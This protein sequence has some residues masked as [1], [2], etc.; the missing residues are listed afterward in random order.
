GEDAVLVS[1]THLKSSPTRGEGPRRRR[2][3]GGGAQAPYPAL[4]KFHHGAPAPP[5]SC[6][7]SPSPFRGGF[8]ERSSPLPPI[9]VVL[10]NHFLQ[11]GR[12]AERLD[13]VAAGFLRAGLGLATGGQF[14]EHMVEALGRQILVIVVVD[15]DHRRRGAVAHAFDLGKG[16]E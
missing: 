8:A 7:W 1:E 13:G 3:R 16:P 6:G 14:V 10:G 11:R 5:P 12:P 4:S 15:L 9:I 2:R